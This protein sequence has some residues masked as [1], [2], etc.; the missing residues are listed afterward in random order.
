MD[1]YREQTD[2]YGY[3]YSL[4]YREYC[5][6]C[7]SI[8][9]GGSTDSSRWSSSADPARW[10]LSIVR[11]N[12]DGT[13][14][15]NQVYH[16]D[17][18]KSDGDWTDEPTAP[19]IDNM[20]IDDSSDPGRHWLFGTSRSLSL[21]AHGAHLNI[22][23]VE[24]EQTTGNLVTSTFYMFHVTD[25]GATGFGKG[26]FA[27]IKPTFGDNLDM[28]AIFISDDRSLYYMVAEFSFAE[29]SVTMEKLHEDMGDNWARAVWI[30]TQREQSTLPGAPNKFQSYTGGAKQSFFDV[31]FDRSTAK[32][33]GV[34]LSNL[35]IA[36]GCLKAVTGTL[37]FT[38]SD[39]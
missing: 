36:E 4:L 22:W 32:M 38:K 33:A 30:G 13:A 11:I 24:V 2:Y 34:I 27:G 17:T 15:A 37:T 18:Y 10:V 16:I 39:K 29:T 6:N 5:P 8:Y 7:G 28:H 21:S 1:W 20:A 19:L 14:P 9:I 35:Q 23:K 3:S 25:P 31:W 26:F 12:E